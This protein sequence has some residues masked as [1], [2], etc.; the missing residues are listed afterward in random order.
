MSQGAGCTVPS[1]GIPNTVDSKIRF[2]CESKAFSKGFQKKFHK[3]LIPRKKTRQDYYFQLF[4][5]CSIFQNRINISGSMFEKVGAQKTKD[6]HKKLSKALPS[7]IR[8]TSWWRKASFSCICCGDC[9]GAAKSGALHIR[10]VRHFSNEVPEL[11]SKILS[12]IALSHM[13]QVS[14]P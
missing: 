7:A 9:H 4:G 5:Y 3:M 2:V 11:L 8:D 13:R 1:H 6:A 12:N 10:K 14:L